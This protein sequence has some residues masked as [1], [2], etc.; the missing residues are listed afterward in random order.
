MTWE[1][2]FLPV[3]LDEDLPSIPRAARAEILRAIRR[4]LTVDPQAYGEPLRKELFGYWKLRV[5][6]WRVIYRIERSRVTVLVVKIRPRKDDKVYREMLLRAR[7]LLG[8]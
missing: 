1:V 3:V 7:R 8:A 5:G 6:D 2:R 4:R